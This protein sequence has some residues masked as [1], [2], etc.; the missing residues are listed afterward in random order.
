MRENVVEEYLRKEVKK[1]GGKAYKFISPGNAGVPDRLVV[2]PGGRIYFIELKAP[3]KKPTPLQLNQM[4][5]LR[6]QGFNVRAI[7]RKEEVDSFMRE[8]MPHEVRTACLPT[9]L[10]QQIAD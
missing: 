4:R 8:V 2:F 9:L 5:Y 6:S 3:G 10:H 7:D 1:Q